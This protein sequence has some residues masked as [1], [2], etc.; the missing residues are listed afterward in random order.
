M[1]PVMQGAAQEHVKLT[2]FRCIGNDR[3]R[4]VHVSDDVNL[5]RVLNVMDDE[6]ARIEPGLAV[7]CAGGGSRSDCP[8]NQAE[9]QA[10]GH[11]PLKTGEEGNHDR[12]LRIWVRR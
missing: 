11:A 5:V 9:G 8:E 1:S 6:F 2:G 10:C 12:V 4:N 3:E 7:V